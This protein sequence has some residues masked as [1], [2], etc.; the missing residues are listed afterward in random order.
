MGS[1]ASGVKIGKTHNL[2]ENAGIVKRQGISK[3][4]LSRLHIP[5][6]SKTRRGLENPQARR[7]IFEPAG[8][9]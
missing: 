6:G 2:V 1:F 7:R 3:G 8:S 4:F 5:Q 9:G